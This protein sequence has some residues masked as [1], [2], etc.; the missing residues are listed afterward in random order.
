VPPRTAEIR[1]R[2]AIDP[3]VRVH[4]NETYAGYEDVTGNS[5]MVLG[6]TVEV[7]EPESG[8]CGLGQITELDSEKRLIYLAVDWSSLA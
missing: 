2:I 6:E 1:H 4:G 8:I 5:G 3:N 7:H